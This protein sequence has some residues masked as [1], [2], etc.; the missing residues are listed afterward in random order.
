[1]R[2]LVVEDETFLADII[3]KGLE[4]EGYAVDVAYNGEEGLFLAES[5]PSDLIILDIMLPLVDGLTILKTIRRAGIRTPVL[6]LTARD[7]VTDKIAGLD[8]GADD[9]LTKPFNFEE[10]LARIRALIRRGSDTRT[11]VIEID[12]LVIDTAAR[13]VSRAGRQ[14]ELSAREYALLEYLAIHNNQVLSRTVLSEHLYD[15]NF[16]LDSNVIDVFISR[17]RNKID[18]NHDKRLIHTV[19]G[20]GYMLKG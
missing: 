5:E 17:L 8:S 11:A 4:E 16:D 13:Y 12:D 20:A 19:R 6:L 10:M 3:R 2:I 9:Y 14:V 18:R 15:Y 7:T 1:M